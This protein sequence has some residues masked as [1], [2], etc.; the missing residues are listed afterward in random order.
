MSTHVAGE[1][2]E[3]AECFRT[4]E[5]VRKSEEK[6]RLLL[7]TTS[8]FIWE[9]DAEARF[10]YTS[11]KVRSLLGYEPDELF[12]KTPLELVVPEERADLESKIRAVQTKPLP[13]SGLELTCSRKDGRRV[14]FELNAAPFFD[15]HGEL[16]G[17]RGSGRDISRRKQAESA[18]QESEDRFRRLLANLPDVAWTSDI[19]G[20]TTYVSANVEALSG[21]TAEDIYRSGDDLWFG[22]IHEDDRRSVLEAC[23]ALVSESRPFDL[24]Y[25][26]QRKDGR[27]IWIR[28]R[29]LRPS[30]SEGVFYA[31]GVLSD[32]TDRKLAEEA[33][34]R[35]QRELDIRNRIA[36]VFLTAS[37]DSAF[38]EVLAVV[39]EVMCSQYGFFGYI[40]DEGAL[41]CPSMTH[42]VWD[43]GQVADKSFRFPREEWC[44]LWGRA[45]IEKRSLYS[46][47]TAYFPRGHVQLQRA[48]VVPIVHKTEL[49]GVLS[50]ANKEADY[51]ESD[52]ESLEL[53]AGYVSAVL[54]A[55]VQRDLQEKT[56][57]KVELV[58]AANEARFRSLVENSWDVIY[59]LD[60]DANITFAS[61]SIPRVLGYSEEECIGQSVFAM[62]H[63]DQREAGRQF[64]AKVLQ[65]P[66]SGLG[67]ECLYRHK[68]RSWC[69]YEYTMRNLLD[70]PAV[71]AVVVTARDITERKQAAVELQ[72]AAEAANAASRA[73][74]EFLANM[75]HEIRTPMNGVIGM[76]ELTLDTTLTADQREY[77]QMAK[78]SSDLLLTVIND[79]LDF[80]KIEA[81]KLNLEE[82]EFDLHDLMGETTNVLAF[83]A[84]QKGLELVCNLGPEVP[85]S[86]IGDPGRLRQVLI[87]LVGNAIKFTTEGE[88]VVEVGSPGT[89]ATSTELLF[90]IS[91]TGI[92]IA[93]EKQVVIFEAFAQADNSATREFGGTGLG[94]AISSRLVGLMGGR[95]SVESA[96]GKGSTFRF[97]AKVGVSRLGATVPAVLPKADLLHVPVLVVDDNATNRR[98]LEATVKDWGMDCRTACSGAEALQLLTDAQASGAPYSVV[99]L[100]CQMPGLDGFS[101][102]DIIRTDLSPTGAV[103]MM[104]T[105][106]DRSG[107]VTRCRHLGIASYLVKP[108]RRSELLNSL[109]QALARH[110]STNSSQPALERAAERQVDLPRRVL[111]AEDNLVNQTFLSRTLQKL[112]HVP[113]LAANGR[114]TI[115]R[116]RTGSYD[117]IFMDVQMPEMDGLSATEAI[118]KLEKSSGTHI[119][120]FAM[121]AHALKGDRE[122]CLAAGM[123]G[124]ISKPATLA[125][126]ASAVNSVP[127]APGGQRDDGE[128][129]DKPDLWN[130]AAALDRVGGDESLLNELINIFL[131]EYPALAQR[132]TEGL[133]RGDLPSLREPAHT[134]KGSFGC[135]GMQDTAVLALEIEKASQARDADR[136]A[137]LID[138]MLSQVG[139]VQQVMRTQSP[140]KTHE[141][142][143]R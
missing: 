109:L 112:G 80:S 77:L 42:E 54:D 78:T 76:L 97:T 24:E 52:R 73:K 75:S 102:A 124:Y 47:E 34:Q 71:R 28:D 58:L 106:A 16:A 68:D 119:P 35:S 85:R 43:A 89:Q 129:Q 46:N 132:L 136:A 65:S 41:V 36:N 30:L 50:I 14:V 5:A 98:I 11:L 96:L 142:A 31:H 111:V 117:L 88:I 70:D 8:E 26:F 10:T 15:A 63:R 82:I 6:Y 120:I 66:D 133:S 12:G 131:Q 23:S 48:L 114:E 51:D 55:R 130:R 1:V 138:T 2:M 9:T 99:L 128:S 139:A 74:S 126:I 113:T 67:S 105:S 20:N 25:R 93:P 56:R 61:P 59:L 45:M 108:I 19:H 121:T 21:Y 100:D 4:L 101:V 94:L 13:F 64:F 17:V 127:P 18:I 44:G 107:D 32:I 57:K 7:E 27:W 33:M 49:I 115:E 40:D 83:R 62:I 135:L 87:N 37:D 103:I 122:R 104:L 39:L 95:I 110:E 116:F 140:G 143:S 69:W 137:S 90:S 91:D 60:A 72:R 134:L 29:A 81:G 38:S 53:I 22:R 123:D 141:P 86:V 3:A 92:G 79:I 84:H 125:E 118:R